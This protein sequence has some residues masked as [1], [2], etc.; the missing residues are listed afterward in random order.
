MSNYVH[1]YSS[2]EAERLKDQAD[3]LAEL[4]HADTRYTDGALVLEAGCGTGAQT[5]SLTA[6]SPGARFHCVDISPAS[7]DVANARVRQAGMEN[8]RFQLADA[9]QLPMADDTYDHVFVC[10]LLEHLHRPEAVLDELH[11][12][13][14][15]G[16]TITVIEGDHGTFFCHPRSAAADRAVRCL[17]DIQAE[18]GG[19]ALI[20]RQL[21][22]LLTAAGF[23]GVRVSPRMVYVDDSRPHL[24]TGFSKQTFIA[25]VEGVE[26]DAVAR[27]MVT[28]EEWAAGIRDLYRATAE[29]G[30]FGYTFF[31]ATATGMK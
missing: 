26:A 9:M 24:V 17:V 18:A 31:K 25:M 21:Y 19:N 5:V 27:G 12:V 3:T 16:G 1:G 2:R 11:R 15:P 22:P 4:L 10:F 7:L 30:V 20:G 8:A 28:A 29:D 13:L 23:G 14:A 6:N